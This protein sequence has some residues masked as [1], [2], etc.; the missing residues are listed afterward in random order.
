[1]S[2]DTVSLPAFE[3]LLDAASEPYWRAGRFAYFFARGKLSRDPAYRAILEQG[4]LQRRRRILDLGCGQGLLISWLRA[5]DTC[6]GE[7]HWPDGWPPPP[8]PDSTRGVELMHG[9]VARAR[10]ALGTG[11]RVEQGDIRTVKFGDVDAV[12]IL[13]VIH[14]MR[15]DEQSQVLHRVRQALSP[16]GLLLMRVGDAGAGIPFRISQWV[17]RLVLLTRGH[18]PTTYCRSVAAW[19]DLLR[20]SGFDIEARPMSDGTPFANV[21]LIANAR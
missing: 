8:R 20:E 15:P 21:L 6:H 10:A 16:G 19:H 13:D 17:D 18:L 5:A 14:Y 2:L 9:D 4:L 12:V 11:C 3:T 7:G 1:L